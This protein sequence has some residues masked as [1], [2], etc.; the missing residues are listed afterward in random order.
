MP[1]LQSR[2]PMYDLFGI[3]LDRNKNNQI[4]V[5]K[6]VGDAATFTGQAVKDAAIAV[7]DNKV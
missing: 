2:S 7:D 3:I 5:G 4:Q 1:P 6:A